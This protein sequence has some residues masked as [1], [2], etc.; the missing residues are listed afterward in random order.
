MQRM[1][2]ADPGWMAM[3]RVYARALIRS[4]RIADAEALLAAHLTSN[5]ACRGLF[6]DLAAS[7]VR[8]DDA[9]RWLR[10]VQRIADPSDFAFG[11]ALLEAW[12]A[13]ATRTEHEDARAGVRAWLDQVAARAD[14]VDSADEADLLI[15]VAAIAALNDRP[16]VARALYRRALDLNPTFPEAANNLALLLLDDTAHL[17][18]AERL[19]RIAVEAGSNSTYRADFLETL[20]RVQDRRGDIA[21]SI[22]SLQAA[23]ALRPTQIEWQARLAGQL[24]AA[25]HAEQARQI[26]QR[27]SQEPNVASQ[28]SPQVQ[29]RIADLQA[30]LAAPKS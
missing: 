7:E 10:H 16:V 27:L 2:P 6:L 26:V 11:V 24:L 28:F 12:H 14:R 19:A 3:A 29:R 13:V 8:D 18:E 4:G 23:V 17:P 15:P 9:M 30:A 5:R 1:T 20:S 25:G 22:G 21:G